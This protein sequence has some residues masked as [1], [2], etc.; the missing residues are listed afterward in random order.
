V[1][2][3]VSVFVR[4][5][6][7]SAALLRCLGAP[8]RTV[9]AIYVI[10]AVALGTLGAAVGV[11]LGLLVQAALPAVV[12]DFIPVRVS[13]AIDWPTVAAGLVIGA[14]TAA[15]FALLP[16]LRLRDVPPLRALRREFEATRV[17]GA[18]RHVARALVVGAL[19]GG[20]V[21]VAIWQAP[22]A[23]VGLAFAGAV[24]VTAGARAAARIL[25]A[26]VRYSPLARATSSAR[27]S[28][29]CSD[30]KTK[31]SRSRSRSASACFSSPRSTWCSATRR[32]SSRSMPPRSPQPRA[33]RH[34]GGSEGR[35]HRTCGKVGGCGRR[36][37]HRPARIARE[38]P[39]A[40]SLLRTRWRRAAST[41]IRIATRW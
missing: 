11:A 1:G 10:Q 39:A 8:A 27:A 38:R 6:L 5:K 23:G 14:A 7:D 40:D 24:F 30:P 31:R 20:I 12:G 25:M 22:S 17:P 32:A 33:V 34:S 29:I 37:T 26:A 16:L 3:A 18:R 4:E 28:P 15:A 36:D 9:L 2:S 41:A 13:V 19:L 21:L 35:C